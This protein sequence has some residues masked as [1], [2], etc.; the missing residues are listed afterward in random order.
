MDFNTNKNFGQIQRLIQVLGQEFATSK[1]NNKRKGGLLGLAAASI[2]LGKVHWIAVLCVLF[3]CFVWLLIDRFSVFWKDTE[4]Y[5]NELVSPVLNCLHDPE[6]RVRLFA[7]ESL[8]NIVKVARASIIPEFPRIF[9]ALSRLVTG[10][11]LLRLKK[12]FW[13]FLLIE[14]HCMHRFRWK[15]Q[16][17]QWTSWST[18]Q[19]KCKHIT[20]IYW[21]TQ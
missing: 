13:D 11:F 19:S 7:S 21:Q 10:K 6:V 16:K 12:S 9:S 3:C 8:Y 2:G 17:W 18:A 20:Q 4:K 15:L 14:F 5:V 1:D